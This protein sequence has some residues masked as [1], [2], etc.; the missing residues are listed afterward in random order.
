MSRHT[1]DSDGRKPLSLLC[2]KIEEEE[3]V[4]WSSVKLGTLEEGLLT[5]TLILEG[6]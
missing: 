4:T 6:Y 1:E 5:G 3:I 2:M